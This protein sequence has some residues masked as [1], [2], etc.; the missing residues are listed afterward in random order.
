MEHCAQSKM[1]DDMLGQLE[2]AKTERRT[3][4]R[5]S[6]VLLGRREYLFVGQ[7]FYATTSNVFTIR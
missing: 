7:N 5:M 2:T 6:L 1:I 4:N 3:G